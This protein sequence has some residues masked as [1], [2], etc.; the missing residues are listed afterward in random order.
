MD[1]SAPVPPA[2]SN[3]EKA[4]AETTIYPKWEPGP[5]LKIPS[6]HQRFFS[7]I[8]HARRTQ[9]AQIGIMLFAL[10]ILIGLILKWD[11]LRPPISSHGLTQLLAEVIR[12]FS[13]L[14]YSPIFFENDNPA[15][16]K[17]PTTWIGWLL[18]A[19]SLLG[20]G[21]L[22]VAFFVW[23]GEIREDWENTLPKRMSVFFLHKGL[24]VIVCRN[25]WLAGEGDLRAWGQQ[26]AAQSVG[27]HILHFY[28][29]VKA[30]DPALA[31]W[32]D[33]KICKHYSV[34]FD[35]KDMDKDKDRK[36]NLF[37]EKYA[38]YC[39]YQNMASDSN[40]VSSV[41]LA[42]LQR[43]VSASVFPFDWPKN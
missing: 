40:I 33:G 29:N 37:L 43:R 17:S 7:I 20:V 2:L 35:L 39:R 42:C 5:D 13:S 25:V 15:S 11:E 23:Y 22:L 24:P 14:W 6:L 3:Q 27:E 12:K 16:S 26:V 31:I 21:T 32:V 38:G 18:N 9:T 34:C 41:P 10:L 19:Q 30:Q 28:P 1:A 36:Q 8:H 4:A